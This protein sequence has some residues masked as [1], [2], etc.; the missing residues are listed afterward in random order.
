M[1]HRFAIRRLNLDDGRS[2]LRHQE[3]GIRTLVHLTEIDD[4]HAFE[5]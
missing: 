1:P 5:R 2:R 3:T 4:D